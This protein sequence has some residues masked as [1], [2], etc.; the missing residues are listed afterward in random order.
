MLYTELLR[1]WDEAVQAADAKD[2][3]GCLEKLEQITEPT[4]RT[5]FNTA[6][7]HLALGHLDLA[8]KALDFTLAKDERLAV[9]FFQRSAVMMQMDRLE[10]ALSDCIWAQQHMRGNM[11]IDYR[12]LGLRFKLYSWQVLYNAAAVY[13][14]MGQWGQ[15]RDVLLS[16]SKERGGGRGVNIDAALDSVMRE[17]VLDP[18]LLPEGVVFRPRKQDVEQLKQ[19]DFLGKAK[20]ISSMIPNDD[21]GG[22]E[23]LRLQKPGYYEPKVDG[24]QDSRYMR[25][26]VPYMA[27]G[28]GQL[29]VPGGAM[30]FLFGDEDRDGMAT[31]IFDGQ[32]GLLPVSLLEPVDV[33]AT[34]GKKG[35]PNGIPL[36][37]EFK[38][39]TR[40]KVLPS[41]APP[42]RVPV[43]ADTP[44]PSYTT[45]T[46]SA[47]LSSE[48]PTYT[49]N[50]ASDQFADASEGVEASFVVVKVHFT[51]TV[52]LSFPLD[53]R[54]DELKESIAQKLGQP[55]SQLRL[56]RRQHGS[57]VLTP[58][59]GGAEEGL[60]LQEVSE[61]GRVTLWCQKE[62]PLTDRPILYQ[63]VALYDY[64]A[65]GPE[66]LE[67]SE[68]DTIDILGEV[69]DEWLEGHCAGNI[70]IFPSCFAYRENISV[71]ETSVL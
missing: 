2:W 20:V 1:L 44:P 60:T 17:E 39:P 28:P 61:A 33:K 25:M 24:A 57:R 37:P 21:F 58:L 51:Y 38:P 56:R 47:P 23:P 30:V 67:F 54:H 16:A 46:H 22:F 27:Q 71:T 70:G 18:L 43:T 48:P 53:T 52:A 8:L 7:A 65:Q 3:E 49:A 32:R 14:R 62:D 45:A 69:N 55:A 42:P 4:S 5:L 6:S 66:D 64:A 31:V 59:E 40:P 9:G 26:R 68:G 41:P 35:V 36:P 13:C 10:E 34:K 11:V 63:M 50:A 15:A 19:K 12:Q 29:T